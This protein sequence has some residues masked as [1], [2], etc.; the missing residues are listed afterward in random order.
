MSIEFYSEMITDALKIDAKM[1][2]M[3]KSI[4]TF[5]GYKR[6]GTLYRS[7][8]IDPWYY[9]QSSIWA[10]ISFWLSALSFSTSERQRILIE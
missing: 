5:L 7:R 6:V 3:P 10:D 8:Y 2:A 9:E 1:E 4:S